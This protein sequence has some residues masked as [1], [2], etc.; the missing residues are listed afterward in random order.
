MTLV[1]DTSDAEERIVA[2]V[3][4][5]IFIF[6][7]L[8][9]VGE[10]DIKYFLAGLVV[11]AVFGFVSV[12]RFSQQ[13]RKIKFALDCVVTALLIGSLAAA[14]SFLYPEDPG[15]RD[16]MWLII[17]GVGGAGII[18]GFAEWRLHYANKSQS[19]EKPASLEE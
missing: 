13:R 3:G 6:A 16:L 5:L 1:F 10:K 19:Q 18:T 12:V 9:A 4:F 7:G 15:G 2:G 11:C 14:A 8:C 17:I